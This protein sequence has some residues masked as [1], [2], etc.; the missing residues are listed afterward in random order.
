[1]G[2]PSDDVHTMSAKL[3]DMI[4]A[5]A[6]PKPFTPQSLSVS[7]LESSQ[8]FARLAMQDYLDDK[9]GNFYVHA[10]TALEL[11]AK[12]FLA[13]MSPSLVVDGRASTRCFML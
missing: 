3:Q 8:G 1:M 4:T 7:L 5:S 10:G 12:A 9:M 6:A 13:D 2:K 11:L